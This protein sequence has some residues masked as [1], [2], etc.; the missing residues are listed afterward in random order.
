MMVL[1]TLMFIDSAGSRNVEEANSPPLSVRNFFGGPKMVILHLT[2]PF[3]IFFAS[4][5]FITMA[6]ENLVR[7]SIRWRIIFPLI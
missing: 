3:T 4:L 7:W 5:L 2:I 6:D 1:S